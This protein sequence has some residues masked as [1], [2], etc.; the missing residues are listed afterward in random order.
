MEGVQS[1]AAYPFYF[2]KHSQQQKN[3]SDSDF[4]F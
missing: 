2:A 4:D 3:R 1:K